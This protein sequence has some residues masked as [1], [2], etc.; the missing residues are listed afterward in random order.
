MWGTR[1]WSLVL[2]E[3]LGINGF[4]VLEKMTLAPDDLVLAEL[5]D[6]VRY[7]EWGTPAHALVL[8]GAFKKVVPRYVLLD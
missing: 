8:L 5:R 6:C 1:D 7:V 4:S 2:R 3:K